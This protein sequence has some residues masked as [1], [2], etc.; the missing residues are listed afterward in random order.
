MGVS[1]KKIIKIILD[2][3]TDKADNPFMVADPHYNFPVGAE[4]FQINART[5][6]GIFLFT[7]EAL[8]GRGRV[9]FPG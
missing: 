6:G 4:V 3:A 7:A 8:R 1:C 5:A 2:K 9:S